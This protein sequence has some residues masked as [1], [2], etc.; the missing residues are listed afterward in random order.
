M[1]IPPNTYCKAMLR[2]VK[3]RR[4]FTGSSF[5]G[6]FCRKGNKRTWPVLTPIIGIRRQAA[7]KSVHFSELRQKSRTPKLLWFR[8]YISIL[9]NTRISQVLL[10]TIKRKLVYSIIDFCVNQTRVVITVHSLLRLAKSAN[11]RL[12]MAGFQCRLPS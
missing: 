9:R 5:I 12:K 4:R 2:Q 10:Y 8:T 11:V 7:L 1:C 6:C 3:A